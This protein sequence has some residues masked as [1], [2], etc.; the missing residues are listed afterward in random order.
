MPLTECEV[1]HYDRLS[2][3]DRFEIARRIAGKETGILLVDLISQVIVVA[4]DE[5]VA[6]AKLTDAGQRIV[7][8][9]TEGQVAE[10]V[11][12]VIVPNDSIPVPDQIDIH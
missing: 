3:D 2:F 1:A 8:V 10:I 4:A 9:S 12:V 6:P 5:V 7:V 11:N